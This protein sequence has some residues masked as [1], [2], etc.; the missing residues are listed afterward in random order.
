M[1]Q[2]GLKEFI[3]KVLVDVAQGI[4]GANE[5]LKNPD[6]N[7]FEVFSLR[8]NKGDSSKIPGIQFDVAVTATQKSA[9]KMGF[10]VALA[11]IGA[12]GKTETSANNEMIHRIKFEIGITS[13]WK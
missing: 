12:G 8:Q 5:K 7:Q 10:F 13:E 1:E 9:D 4:R 11:S 2:I 3:E 6:K